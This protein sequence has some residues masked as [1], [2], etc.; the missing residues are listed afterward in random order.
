MPSSYRLILNAN[1]FIVTLVTS[2]I[3]KQT[4]SHVV[5][6]CG[7]SLRAKAAGNHSSSRL[8]KCCQKA[9]HAHLQAFCVIAVNQWASSK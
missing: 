1:S 4:E 6:Y 7:G 2:S 8:H 9:Y 5:W 3:S